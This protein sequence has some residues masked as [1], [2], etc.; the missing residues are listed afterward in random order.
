VQALNNGDK[1]QEVFSY[2]LTDGDGDTS[3]KTLTITING[4]DEAPKLESETPDTKEDTPLI[5]NVLD[6]D[7]GVSVAGKVTHFMIN[8]ADHSAD[9]SPV[10]IM[11]STGTKTVGEF[12]LSSNGDYTFTPH[13]DYSGPVPTVTYYTENAT[14]PATLT[15]DVTPVADVPVVT[16]ELGVPQLAMT[17]ITKDN[18]DSKG[19]GFT[20][21]ALNYGETYPSDAG[22]GT[23]AKVSTTSGGIY[24]EGFG[25]KS[26]ETAEY[27]DH[28]RPDGANPYEINYDPVIKQSEGVVITFDAPVSSLAISFSWLNTVEYAHY[29]IYDEKG[30]LIDEG[31]IQGLS[32]L[33]NQITPPLEITGSKG[34]LIKTIVISATADRPSAAITQQ[35]DF[36]INSISYQRGDTIYP[37]DITV[38]PTDTDGSES[39]TSVIVTVTGGELVAGNG[40]THN[41]DGTWTLSLNPNDPGGLSYTVTTD[42]DGTHITGLEMMASSS[43]SAVQGVEVTVTATITDH[44]TLNAVDV[45]DTTTGSTTVHGQTGTAGADTLTGTTGNDTLVGSAGND[46]LIG[47]AGNDVLSGG[48]GADT[49]VW[50]LGDQG[51]AGAP[52]VDTVTDFNK[53]AYSAGGDVLNLKDLLQGELH[54]GNN[55]GNLTDFL[56]FEKSGSDTIIHVSSSGGF[57]GDSGTVGST[58]T[59]SAADQTIVLQN[60]D[61]VGSNTLDQQIITSL[62]TNGKLITD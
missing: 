28:L 7:G 16:V 20:A 53:A 10:T 60:V 15:I 38:K 32:D 13:L 34:E 18:V 8:G 1:L 24:V 54:S 58:F 31:N 46:T 4:T 50:K 29:A 27:L 21:K 61:L 56:H 42:A 14:D 9:G 51:G 12:T 11:D 6:N 39:V 45:Y 30:V 17:V 5:G 33:S 40:I 57:S 52:A 62:L 35:S 41:A 22:T 2:T 55:A 25:V 26:P 49:F 37:V 44:A 19:Q 48:T 36:L 47:G 43:I 59:G 3:T 23:F